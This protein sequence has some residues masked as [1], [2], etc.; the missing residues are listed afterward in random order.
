MKFVQLAS[1]W[2]EVGNNYYFVLV[3]RD[4]RLKVGQSCPNY[5]QLYPNN[6]TYKYR[7]Q[8]V[9]Y[10]IPL[11]SLANTQHKKTTV[12]YSNKPAW[13]NKIAQK[14]NAK[15]VTWSRVYNS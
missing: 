14:T 13:I 12:E 10:A 4:I 6:F 2:E 15:P 8:F 3:N 7:S 11:L 1:S 9:Q 5:I